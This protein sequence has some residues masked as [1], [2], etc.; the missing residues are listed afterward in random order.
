M[1]TDPSKSMYSNALAARAGYGFS[2]R[3]IRQM[4]PKKSY[5][6]SVCPPVPSSGTRHCCSD[7]PLRLGLKT[8]EP[9]KKAPR[10]TRAPSILSHTSFQ[11]LPDL[12]SRSVRGGVHIRPPT[13]TL[14]AHQ[15]RSKNPVVCQPPAYSAYAP[16]ALLDKKR[17][18]FISAL[19]DPTTG[20]VTASFA[21]LGDLNSPNRV[22]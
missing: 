21:M 17:L 11:P 8:G 12:I 3:F 6:G 16:L 22:L 18:P 14:S 10:R 19:T 1:K 4:L 2:P 13:L 7:D 9:L 20:G 15:N 5:S